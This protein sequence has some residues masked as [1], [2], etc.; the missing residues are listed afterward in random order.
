VSDF[1]LI[2]INLNKSYLALSHTLNVTL[3]KDIG[4]Y[5]FQEIPS[6]KGQIIT[7]FVKDYKWFN[8]TPQEDKIYSAILVD[9]KR[10][11]PI[12][13]KQFSNKWFTTIKLEIHGLETIIVSAYFH[14]SRNI[15]YDLDFLSSIVKEFSHLNIIISID[16]NAHSEFWG[17]YYTDSRGK[18]VEEFWFS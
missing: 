9:T 10:F 14:G 15:L 5:C 18:C 3:D 12:L 13:L 16:S 1:N 7:P 8:H 11:T 6:L 17:N 4:I 2:Q